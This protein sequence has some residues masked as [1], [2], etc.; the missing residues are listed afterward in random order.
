M[1]QLMVTM[2]IL[3]FTGIAETAQ[4]ADND[5][6]GNWKW[7]T[8]RP[9]PRKAN[10]NLLLKLKVEGEKLTGSMVFGDKAEFPIEDGTFKDN[11]ITFAVFPVFNGMKL[12][13]KYTGTVS[14]D[15]I[16]GK[17]EFNRDGQ[18]ESHDWEAMRE[19]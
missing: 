17:V 19:K 8:P 18:F 3:A 13:R 1:K 12:S 16:K 7:Q 5:P 10:P 9:A 2:V 15:V 4:A 11:A 6:T 14:G